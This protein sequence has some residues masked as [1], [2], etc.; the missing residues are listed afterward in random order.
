MHNAMHSSMRL[1]SLA[2]LALALLVA[3]ATSEGEKSAW[4]CESD[5]F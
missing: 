1:V 2:V 5:G 4:T 3:P